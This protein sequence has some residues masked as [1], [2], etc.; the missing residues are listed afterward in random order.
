MELKETIKKR[1]SIRK[2]KKMD[3]SNE[4]VKDLIECAR[5]T[6]SAKNRQN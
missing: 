5:L 1:R 3:I 2:F 6:P 4:I